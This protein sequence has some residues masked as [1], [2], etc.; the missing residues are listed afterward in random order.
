MRGTALVLLLLAAHALE[1]AW[2][3]AGGGAAPVGLLRMPAAVEPPRNGGAR[4]SAR[5]GMWSCGCPRE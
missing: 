2:A 4:P 3:F 1:G 5:D